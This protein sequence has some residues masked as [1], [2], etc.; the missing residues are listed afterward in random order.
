MYNSFMHEVTEDVERID[1]LGD[2]SG[3]HHGKKS[4]RVVSMNP[5][6]LYN[7]PREYKTGG[8]KIGPT[9][10]EESRSYE[11]GFVHRLYCVDKLKEFLPV[12]RRGRIGRRERRNRA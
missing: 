8:L 10:Q 2:F 9:N 3:H 5:P 6:A 12:A 11:N 7:H 1:L 4:I